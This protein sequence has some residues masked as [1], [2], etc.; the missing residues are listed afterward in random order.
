LLKQAKH[1]GKSSRREILKPE[2]WNHMQTV[3]PNSGCEKHDKSISGLRQH[4]YCHTATNRTVISFTRHNTGA[5][6]TLWIL[7]PNDDDL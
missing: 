6:P 1:Y 4:R 5:I 7:Q 2:L 3:I